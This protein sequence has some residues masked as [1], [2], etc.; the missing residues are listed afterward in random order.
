MGRPRTPVDRWRAI[1]EAGSTISRVRPLPGYGRYV[2]P[3]A[4]YPHRH[5]PMSDATTCGGIPGSGRLPGPDDAARIPGDGATHFGRGVGLS[6]GLHRASTR[7][8]GARSQPTGLQPH[9]VPA[10]APSN[11]ATWAELPGP[12][13]GWWRDR[14]KADRAVRASPGVS[15]ATAASCGRAR[16]RTSPEQLRMVVCCRVLSLMVRMAAHDCQEESGM[17]DECR[18]D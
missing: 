17:T 15:P 18:R 2:F 8:R 12:A 13:R 11:D 10:R 9:G 3:N 5:R 7:P 14:S 16:P 4:R 6:A 1:V